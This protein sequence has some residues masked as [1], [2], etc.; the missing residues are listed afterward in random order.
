MAASIAMADSIACSMAVPF[1]FMATYI[2]V[3]KD[4]HSL[5]P[6]REKQ[7]ETRL[8]LFILRKNGPVNLEG[9]A[10]AKIK[11]RIDA[12][13]DKMNLDE[14]TGTSLYLTEE[15]PAITRETT[16]ETYSDISRGPPSQITIMCNRAMVDQTYS[17]QR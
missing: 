17:K 11:R 13:L 9:S 5:T 2:T 4:H 15:A 7:R 12:E 16:L 10:G 1:T 3:E 6:T 14:S 8:V